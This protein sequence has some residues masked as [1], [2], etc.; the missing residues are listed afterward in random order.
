LKS[1]ITERIEWAEE[2]WLER[3]RPYTA[4]LFEE[5]FLPSHDQGH[6]SRVWNICKTLLLDLEKYDSVA[7]RG[8]VEG[9]LLASWLHDTGMVQDPG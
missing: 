9:L 6:H 4:Q 8:L 7:D 2:R 3:V 5:T 1:S